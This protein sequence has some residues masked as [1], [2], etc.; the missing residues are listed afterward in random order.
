MRVPVTRESMEHE[1]D[2][3]PI[4]FKVVSFL[5][6]ELPRDVQAQ[7][8]DDGLV[9]ECWPGMDY[10]LWYAAH[11][12]LIV[13]GYLLDMVEEEMNKTGD[14]CGLISSIATLR[15]TNSKMA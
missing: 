4:P 11:H 15:A 7:I 3:D 8:I 5:W 13:P 2:Y 14:Y 1:Y 6:D 9:G 12:D 10:A